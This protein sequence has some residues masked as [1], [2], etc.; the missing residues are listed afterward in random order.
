MLGRAF[1]VSLMVFTGCAALFFS[2]QHGFRV[3]DK[4]M[5]GIQSK[6]SVI[7]SPEEL[8]VFF[9]SIAIG[10]IAGI[11][12]FAAAVTWLVR[13]FRPCILRV[14]AEPPRDRE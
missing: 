12:A 7:L 3:F 2:Y 1:C 9:G 13:L 11:V 8:L 5:W 4:S 10:I 6:E 14:Q